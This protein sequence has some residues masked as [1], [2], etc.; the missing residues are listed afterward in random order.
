MRP[1]PLERQRRK[2]PHNNWKYCSGAHSIFYIHV[3]ILDDDI[4]LQQLSMKCNGEDIDQ[5]F[6]LPLH[7]IASQQFETL[8]TELQNRQESTELD[9]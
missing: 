6:Y 4:T 8:S 3:D 9:N 7:V 2:L 1:P 5:I